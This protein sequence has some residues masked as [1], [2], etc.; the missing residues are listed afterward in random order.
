[1]S[2]FSIDPRRGR[3]SAQHLGQLEKDIGIVIRD[4]ERVRSS[5]TMSG[6]RAGSPVHRQIN[7]PSIGSIV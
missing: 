3:I 4:M 5:C 6:Q 2:S 7:G 1:M